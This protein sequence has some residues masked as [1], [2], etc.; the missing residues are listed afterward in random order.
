MS[1]ELS[2]LNSLNL[3]PE[4]FETIENLAATNYGPREIAIYLSVDIK[5]FLSEFRLPDSKVRFHYNKGVLTASFE[6]DNTLLE[7]AKNGDIDAVK[8]SK[9]AS[10]KRAFQNHKHRI[11]NEY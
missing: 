8:E 4:Q 11:L 10:E 9:K 6:I 1:Q 3:S 2:I 7:F 5:K